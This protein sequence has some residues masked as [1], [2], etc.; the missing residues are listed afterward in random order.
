MDGTPL[1]RMASNGQINSAGRWDIMLSDGAREFP[2]GIEIGASD[3]KPAASFVGCWGNAR[4]LPRIEVAGNEIEFVSP[5]R[6]EGGKEDML[7]KGHFMDRR[8]AGTAN[9]PDGNPWT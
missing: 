8:I 4:P 3:G 5:K 6:E 7:F 9:G 1:G 2:S